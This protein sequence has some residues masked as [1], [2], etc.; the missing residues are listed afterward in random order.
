MD[1]DRSVFW[2]VWG[3][4]MLTTVEGTYRNGK[5]ELAEAPAGLDHAHVLVT[6][7]P[8]STEPRLPKKLYGNWRSKMP[9]ELDLDGALSE[10]RG[11]K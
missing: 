11:G 9:A 10:I 5:I 2:R 8:M 6:F 4:T 1:G 3:G 7:L